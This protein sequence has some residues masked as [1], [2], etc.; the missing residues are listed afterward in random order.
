MLYTQIVFCETL[1]LTTR[2]PLHFYLYLSKYL[3]YVLYPTIK[4]LNRFHKS[5]DTEDN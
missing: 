3:I 2:L 1:S 4:L 5:S